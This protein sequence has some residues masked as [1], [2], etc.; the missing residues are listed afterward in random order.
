MADPI[1]QLRSLDDE[2]LAQVLTDMPEDDL[3]ILANALSP[4]DRP[5]RRLLERGSDLIDEATSGASPVAR[6]PGQVV[7]GAMLGAQDVIDAVPQ[8]LKLAGLALDAGV[9]RP[10][11]KG[12]IDPL[13]PGL[14]AGAAVEQRIEEGVGQPIDAMKSMIRQQPLQAVDAVGGLGG[15]TAGALTGASMGAAGGPPGMLF[16]AAIGAGLG[17]EA[18]KL[19]RDK[20]L[21]VFN[22]E[23]NYEP[24]SIKNASRI[25]TSLALP[26][27]L[28]K[29]GASLAKGVKAKGKKLIQERAPAPFYSTEKQIQREM[30]AVGGDYRN[31]LVDSL[32]GKQ[33]R[34]NI[35]RAFAKELTESADDFL[36]SGVLRN[37][38]PKDP[39]VLNTLST[40]VD[41]R[42]QN[43]VKLKEK[44]LS[45]PELST[46]LVDVG[47]ISQ[48]LQPEF[49][50]LL[51]TSF[52]AQM[53]E[54][55]ISQLEKFRTA[56]RG[57]SK[58]ILPEK[59]IKELTEEAAQIPV[60]ELQK[61]I[62]NLDE[63]VKM[64]G[65]YDLSPGAA[66]HQNPSALAQ[67]QAELSAAR[68]LRS[69]LNESLKSEIG[70]TLGADVATLF[71]DANK[72]IGST[73][74]WKAAIDRTATENSAFISPT[75]GKSLLGFQQK[76]VG[77]IG[78][79][80]TDLIS[81]A[82]EM[83][84]GEGP[85]RYPR[86][87]QI[88]QG[89]KQKE[90]MIRRAQYIQNL[91]DGNIPSGAASNIPTKQGLPSQIRA[92]LD[93]APSAITEIIIPSIYVQNTLGRTVESARANMESLLRD[94]PPEVA[95][96]IGRALQQARG[97]KVA[98]ARIMGA[99]VAEFHE[100]AEKFEP[101]PI[102]AKSEFAGY[103]A[104]P[105]EKMMKGI[106]L[107]R[108]VRAGKESTIVAAKAK[109]AMNADIP[110]DKYPPSLLVDEG[111]PGG[112]DVFFDN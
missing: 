30:A 61:Q 105:A 8:T 85:T 73:I 94:S 100:L 67:I 28:A 52:T 55:G 17:S 106:E 80:A 59:L 9:S 82:A 81:G 79:M 41:D 96:V 87:K 64:N 78:E 65:G 72:R 18:Y 4:K 27:P 3:A 109:S 39:N 56:F 108:N 14:G 5:E 86:H 60:S 70:L 103:I 101:S 49:D 38:D 104:D 102:G 19:A 54:E 75:S 20:V 51:K 95:E 84:T 110:M 24:A 6:I 76:G 69:A 25:A 45:S 42:L 63:F 50:T 31:A 62:R 37:L 92:T 22:K 12:V 11:A 83:V 90:E 21:S 99:A 89:L 43:A 98:Q 33:G 58:L 44:I 88:M 40:R 74:D 10:V 1:E 36:E 97:D 32:G 71:E 57:E 68:K 107:S 93:A 29:G 112:I 53:G 77:G 34:T 111:V 35:E 15:L 13:F 47:E 46:K 16:G 26:D 23:N 2:T 66:V 7:S 48:S 91:Y